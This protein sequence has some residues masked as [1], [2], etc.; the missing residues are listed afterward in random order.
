M[1]FDF[2]YHKYSTEYPESSYRVK[3]GGGYQYSAP[4]S[5][6]DQ[7]IFKLKFAAMKYFVSNGA[8]DVTTKPEINLA[9]LEQFY[10]TNK[11][12]QTFTYPHPVLG[13]LPVR[14]NKPLAI[15]EG[16]EG[17]DG[18]VLNVE[19]ELIEQPGLSASS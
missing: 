17:G 19:V 9:R 14:F 1:I 18:V 15:P 4:P 12:N 13:D 11:M 5:A 2:P 16:L 7:R 6:P 8:I 3:L 10:N